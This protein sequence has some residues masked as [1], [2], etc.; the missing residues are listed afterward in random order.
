M[1]FLSASSIY[2]MERGIIDSSH[3]LLYK[4]YR[5]AYSVYLLVKLRQMYPN[6][7]IKLMYDIASLCVCKALEGTF[8]E[9]VS[10]IY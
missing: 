5:I 10:H 3:L 2:V 1:N 4:P 6:H 7:S 9:Y 8:A